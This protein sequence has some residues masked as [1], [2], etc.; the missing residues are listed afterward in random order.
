MD[1]NLQ[2]EQFTTNLDEKHILAMNIA[3]DHLETSFDITKC[4]GFKDFLS[5]KK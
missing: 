5:Q 4:N 1:I 2:V 3:K